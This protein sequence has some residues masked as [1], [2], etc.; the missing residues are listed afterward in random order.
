MGPNADTG[1]K[2]DDKIGKYIGVACHRYHL[3][4]SM[5][6]LYKNSHCRYFACSL[7]MVAVLGLVSVGP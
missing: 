3:F 5:S 7:N 1:V 2:A 4:V 6:A